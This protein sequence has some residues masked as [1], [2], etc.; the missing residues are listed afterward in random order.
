MYKKNDRP[1]W[2]DGRKKMNGQV[3]STTEKEWSHGERERLHGVPSRDVRSNLFVVRLPAFCR[4]SKY[5]YD[6]ST[7]WLFAWVT[8]Y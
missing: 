3:E 1:N 6:V 5:D 7:S 2:I 8:L 4:K